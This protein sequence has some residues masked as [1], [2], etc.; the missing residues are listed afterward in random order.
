MASHYGSAKPSVNLRVL[1]GSGAFLFGQV[2]STVTFA[3]LGFAVAPLSFERRYAVITNWTHFNLWWLRITCGLRHEILGFENIPS[4]PSVILCKHES[5]WETLALQTVFC[6]QSW[7]L[8][9]ELLNI[10][11]FGWGLRLLRPIA[12][13]RSAGRKA[14]Q[15]LIKEGRDRLRSG[16]WIVVFPEGT[17]VPPGTKRSFQ[18]GG[19]ALAKRTGTMVTPVAHNAGDFWPRHG[20]LKF[21]GVIRLAIGPGIETQD[22]SIDQINEMAKQWID[23]CVADLRTSDAALRPRPLPR[24]NQSL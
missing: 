12:I 22:R 15:S 1:I 9:R 6:P 3:M 13:D 20:F 11:F 24:V 14:L 5:A 19:A 18:K 10:P 8:K 2:I 23:T 4:M 16:C 17:R 21:P 7:V